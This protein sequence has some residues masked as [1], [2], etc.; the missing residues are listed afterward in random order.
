MDD[1]AFCTV[2]WRSLEGVRHAGAYG[3]S[4]LH[5]GLWFPPRR[6]ASVGSHGFQKIDDKER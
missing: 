4:V 2:L 3:C 5:G 6:V 1:G